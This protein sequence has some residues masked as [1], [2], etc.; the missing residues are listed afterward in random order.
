MVGQYQQA[1]HASRFVLSCFEEDSSGDLP[2]H[3]REYVSHIMGLTGVDHHVVRDLFGL[4]NEVPLGHR[5]QLSQ[6]ERL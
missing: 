5:M 3:V 4:Q 6:V 1:I 2:G